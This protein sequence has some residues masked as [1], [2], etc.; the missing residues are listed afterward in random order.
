MVHDYCARQKTTGTHLKFFVMRQLPVLTPEHYDG[1]APWGPSGAPLD[2]WITPRVLELTYTAYDI[3]A[4]A[5]D[6]GDDGPPF[7]WIPERRDLIRAELDA[8]Y[9]HLYGVERDDVDYIMDTFKVV[10]QNDVKRHGEYHTKRLILE[11][12]DA[13][14]DAIRTGRPY[15]TPLDPLPGEGPR[16]PPKAG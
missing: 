8:A 5:R 14:A 16:H 9:F 13:L 4:Y 12:Y 2:G 1:P 11:R 6:L 3:A 15:R 7:R 10:R